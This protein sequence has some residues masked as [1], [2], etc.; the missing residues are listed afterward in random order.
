MTNN[1][2]IKLLKMK[3]KLI[4]IAFTLF[5][6][7]TLANAQ[8]SVG[9]LGGVNFQNLNGKSSSGDVLENTMI[10]GFHAGLNLQIP[11]A[12]EFYFE[13]GL[14]FTTKGAKKPGSILTATT[15]LSYIEMPLNFLYKGSLGSGF[16]LVAVGPYVGYAIKGNVKYEGG[17]VTVDSPVKFQNVVELTD[18]PLV[19]YYRALDAGANIS[20]GYEMKSGIFAKVNAQLGMININPE[21]KLLSDDKSAVK[22]TGFG[23]SLG[24]QF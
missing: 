2:I 17:A 18:S 9:V 12:P 23:V 14:L 7:S 3:T 22:N 20:F 4:S 16:I 6:F 19:P 21:Y 1:L 24:Y 13:P 10:P 11:V 15:S 5:L 8:I